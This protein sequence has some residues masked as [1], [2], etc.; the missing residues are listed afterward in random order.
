MAATIAT[1]MCQLTWPLKE[2][3]GKINTIDTPVANQMDEI[4]RPIVVQGLC[5]GWLFF[6]LQ[7]M[8]PHSSHAPSMVTSQANGHRL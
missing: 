6:L 2:S 1:K 4:A 7:I 5:C 3:A 8:A